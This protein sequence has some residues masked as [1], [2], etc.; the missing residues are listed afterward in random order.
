MALYQIAVVEMTPLNHHIWRNASS[1]QKGSQ[2]L[3]TFAKSYYGGRIPLDAKADEKE[4]LEDWEVNETVT[5][6]RAKNEG[7]V[8]KYDPEN[9]VEYKVV[10]NK[11]NEVADDAEAEAKMNDMLRSFK[12]S[13]MTSE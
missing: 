9:K 11:I 4:P 1:E 3:R 5:E 6:L 7:L 10:Y 13:E 12:Q 8:D 2:S